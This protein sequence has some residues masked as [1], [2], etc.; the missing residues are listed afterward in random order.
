[1]AA[2]TNTPNL[3]EFETIKLQL[4][5]RTLHNPQLSL[6][7]YKYFDI[8]TFKRW[9]MKEQII[10]K[11]IYL[12]LKELS[13]E[14]DIPK[15]LRSQYDPDYESPGLVRCKKYITD[16]YTRFKDSQITDKPF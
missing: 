4:L 7:G 10:I 15:Y 6:Y 2:N 12:E 1:M 8:S 11:D 9:L 3:T 5:S 16:L 14:T 13:I